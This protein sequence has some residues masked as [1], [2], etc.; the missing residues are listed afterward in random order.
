MMNTILTLLNDDIT[1][2]KNRLQETKEKTKLIKTNKK[3][4]YYN[5]ACCFDLESSSFYQDFI[6]KSENKRSIMYAFIFSIGDIDI[7]GRSWLDYHLIYNTI[8]ETFMTDI[9]TRLIIFVHNLSYDFQFIRTHHEFESVFALDERDAIKALTTDGIEFRCSYKLS[10]YSLMKVG[11][12]LTEHNIK[13]MV[14]DLDYSLIRTPLTPLSEREMNYI[15]HDGRVVVAYIEEEMKNYSNN[16]TKIPLTKT[17]KVRNYCRGR[18]LYSKTSHKK[19]DP[20]YKKYRRVMNKMKITSVFEYQHLHQCFMGGYTHGNNLNVGKICHNISSFDFSSSYPSVMVAEQYPMFTGE[21]IQIK[22]KEE[23][24]RNISLYNCIFTAT[25]YDID[26][27]F[28]YE[29]YISSSKCLEHEEMTQDNGRVVRAKKLT[30]CITEIDY[31]IIK[32]T[33]KWKRLLI[34]N[35]RRYRKGYLPTEFISSILDLYEKKTTLKGIEEYVVEYQQS[36]ENINSCYGMTV[37]N[38]CRDDI[39]YDSNNDTWGTETPD[40]E[41]VIN[42]YNNDVRRFLFY[43]WGIYVTAYARRN[44]WNAI[45]YLK[46]DYRYSDT[47]SVKFANLDKHKEYFIKYNKIIFQR[48]KRVLELH[49]I[50]INKIIPKTKEGNIKL[51]GAWDYEG[52]FKNLKYLGA[53]RYLTLDENN[54]LS[55]TVSGLNKFMV[56]PYLLNKHKIKYE[57]IKNS[58]HII[59]DIEKVNVIFDE[60]KEGLYIP[61]GKTGKQIHTYIDTEQKGVIRDYLGQEYEYDELSGIHMED[62]DYTLDLSVEFLRYLLGVQQMIF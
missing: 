20:Q 14:G 34:R 41:K 61:K 21:R 40:Y 58:F 18:C 12:H 31:E 24:E 53:K 52:T 13:K 29:H 35:F 10:G 42:K 49:N 36:K 5:I 9:N 62:A 1:T 4:N 46:E 33:Y 50:D 26:E 7:I 22:N 6:I 37:T 43:P 44:L 30:M 55:L 2:I 11:E 25:F 57:R 59:D 60:F 48:L 39:T 16:I 45:L 3:I 17:G 51:L 8:I 27:T 19:Y 23:F 56:I 54:N 47:D 38:I 28:I 32:K 15:I